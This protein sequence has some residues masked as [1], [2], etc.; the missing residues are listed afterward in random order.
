M[1]RLAHGYTNR[2]RR[3][4]VGVGRGVEK[5]YDG[6]DACFRAQTEFTCLRHLSGRFRVPEVLSYDP[7]APKIVLREHVGTNGQELLAKGEGAS[8]LRM[9]GSCLATL[10]SFHPSLVPSLDGSGPV[11]VHG[12]FGP[13]NILCAPGQ[14]SVSAVL[15]WEFAHVGSPIE[16]VA[17]AEWIVR[18]HHSD[19]V[20]DLPELFSAADLTFSWADRQASM[21]T[22]CKRYIARCEEEGGSNAAAAAWVRRLR[23]T[24]TWH[25]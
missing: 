11:I 14:T 23:T 3:V 12:D 20:D 9:I 1:A 18:M 24:E 8:V 25:E 10:Q 4:R 6:F 16:D 5:H 17:W 13:Q 22:Q 21:V 2:T 15:D 7:T 19:V